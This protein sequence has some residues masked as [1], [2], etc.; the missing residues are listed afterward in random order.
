MFE[1]QFTD[2][3]WSAAVMPPIGFMLPPVPTAAGPPFGE[4][5]GL[6]S[7]LL[8]SLFFYAGYAGFLPSVI[9]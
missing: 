6:S 7:P 2:P 8:S 1:P 4:G 5:L 3:A 9:G